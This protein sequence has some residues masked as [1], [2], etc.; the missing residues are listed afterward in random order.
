VAAVLVGAAAAAVVLVGA[1]AAAAV[2]LVGAA[3]AAAVL[4][5]AGA[6]VA[7]ESPPQA[8]RIVTSTIISTRTIL[9]LRMGFPPMVFVNNLNIRKTMKTICYRLPPFEVLNST[10]ALA[11]NSELVIV[12]Q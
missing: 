3:A 4:V 5:G 2:V 11:Q 6:G 12:P 10:L 9:F 1:A 7:V 8:V